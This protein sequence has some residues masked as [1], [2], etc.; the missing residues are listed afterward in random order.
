M[1]G[2]GRGRGRGVSLPETRPG[3]PSSELK[4][5]KIQ[6][7]ETKQPIPEPKVCNFDE[8]CGEFKVLKVTNCQDE[9]KNLVLKA[10]ESTKTDE[11][12]SQIIDILYQ[13]VFEDNDFAETVAQLG[14]Q[15]SSLEEIGGKFR[16]RLLKRAQEHYKNREKLCKD[17]LSEWTGLLS[18]LCEIFRI[19][20]ISGE[21]LKPLTGPIY[22]MLGEILL[23]VDD[24]V[25]IECFYQNFKNVGK[26][27][28]TIDKV[29]GRGG[30]TEQPLG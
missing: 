16:S 10:K 28:Q 27:L 29:C 11:N 13:K 18:L 2:R 23:N 3:E 21:P 22:E 6:S 14:N 30:N 19:L 24:G 12:F 15:L 8:L 9:V 20:K 7:E 4:P 1:A 25:K 5:E 26:M 17:S